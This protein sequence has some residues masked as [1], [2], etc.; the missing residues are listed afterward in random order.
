MEISHMFIKQEQTWINQSKEIQPIK[1]LRWWIKCVF[2]WM[3][4]D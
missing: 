1:K 2:S 4:F 3:D